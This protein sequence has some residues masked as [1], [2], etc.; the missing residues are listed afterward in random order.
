MKINGAAD[1]TWI[2]SDN[3]LTLGAIWT[4]DLAPNKPGE[5]KKL[6]K[7]INKPPAT[8]AGIIG[9]KMSDKSLIKAITGLN[10]WS[11]WATFFKSSVENSDRPVIL[12]NSS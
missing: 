10:F 5:V 8:K 12:I 2:I 7:A 6:F 9:T 3:P 4:T 11:F 1:I